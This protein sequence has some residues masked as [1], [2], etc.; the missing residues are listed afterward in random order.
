MDARRTFCAML[1]W[2]TTSVVVLGDV[3][4]E[5]QTD[6]RIGQLLDRVLPTLERTVG[7]VDRHA[8]LPEKSINPFDVDQRSNQS[9][10]DDLLDKAIEVLAVSE[11]TQL[12]DQI[13]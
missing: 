4:V 11:V 13:R 3:S 5:S 12:R 1:F 7:L 8:S 6:R 9:D 2:V 10:I